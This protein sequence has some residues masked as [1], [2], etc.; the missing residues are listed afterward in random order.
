ML[1][2]CISNFAWYMYMYRSMSTGIC[3]IGLCYY[4]DITIYMYNHHHQLTLY[5]LYLKF[6]R[7]KRAPTVQQVYTGPT[8]GSSQHKD[9]SSL[10]RT[11]DTD[12]GR[13]H[14][15]TV[16][17]S[18]K[19]AVASDMYKYPYQ[20]CRPS[21][22]Y[23][24]NIPEATLPAAISSRALQFGTPA[25]APPR[26]CMEDDMTS[27]HAAS[28]INTQP[29]VRTSDSSSSSDHVYEIPS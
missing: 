1:W 3:P 20:S 6:R 15:N 17:F 12:P 23:A 7:Y 22:P 18:T 9:T 21:I 11:Y 25:R 28:G 27:A 8:Y 10:Y 16:E 5:A 26:I 4:F 24:A 14:Q 19:S 29:Y 2:C 13:R